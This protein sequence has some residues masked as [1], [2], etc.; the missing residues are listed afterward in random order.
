MSVVEDIL[1][2]IGLIEQV[3]Y[4]SAASD[5][6]EKPDA[7]FLLPQQS[8]I[9]DA[10]FPLDHYEAFLSTDDVHAK[11]QEKNAF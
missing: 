8:A 1:Q 10:K 11:E 7:T 6:G 5:P 9:M 4:V 2:Y 3:N